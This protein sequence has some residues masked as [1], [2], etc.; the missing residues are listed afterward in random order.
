MKIIK[1][2]EY[3]IIEIPSKFD[4]QELIGFLQLQNNAST[5]I[6]IDFSKSSLKDDL[7]IKN[8]LPFHFIWQKRNKSFILVSNIRHD[9]MKDLIS[10]NTLEE[11]IDYF[12]MEQLTRTI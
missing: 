1:E 8:L 12:H 10:L 11:A 7:I 3:N 2:K 5:S 9:I 4:L 6:I